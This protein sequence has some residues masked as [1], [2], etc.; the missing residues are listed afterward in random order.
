MEAWCW[1][2]QRFSEEVARVIG[3]NNIPKNN[4]KVLK[5][6]NTKNI[7]SNENLIRNHLINNGFNEVIN[8]PFVGKDFPK[9]IRVDNP[10]DSNRK[11]LRLNI[12][13]S[14]LKTLITMKKDRKSQ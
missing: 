7:T 3:Y 13:N 2:Y 1:V 11:F 10:L 14:L 6:L 9:S 4:L 5:T 8:D 12:I